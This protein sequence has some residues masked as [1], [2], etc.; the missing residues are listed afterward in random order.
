[1]QIGSSEQLNESWSKLALQMVSASWENCILK[2]YK[3]VLI[4]KTTHIGNP[5]VKD[6]TDKNWPSGFIVADCN[7]KKSH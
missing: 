1:M 7:S 2:C 5:P 6:E 3:K 4:F